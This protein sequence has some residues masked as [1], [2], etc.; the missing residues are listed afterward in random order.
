L[1]PSPAI[2]RRIGPYEVRSP[3]GKGGMGQVWRA[4]DTRLNR[5]VAIKISTERFTLRFDRESRIVAALNHPNICTVFDVGPNYMVMELVEGVTLAERIRTGRIPVD[6]ALA[7]AEQI[8]SGLEAAHEK[9]VVHRDLKPANIMIRPDGVV[10]IL[11]FGLARPGGPKPEVTPDSPTL[12]ETQVGVIL[13]TAAY[14]SPEQAE[15]KPVDARADIFSYGVVLYE[16][17]SGRKAFP[18]SSPVSVLGAILHKEV[19]PLEAPPEIA[20]VVNRCLRKSPQDRFQT[21][22]EVRRASREPAARPVESV[23]SIAVLP[24]SNAGG[25][26]EN[27]YF[28]D[29]LSEEILN[30]LARLPGLKVTARTSAFAFRG[31]DEDVSAIAR[32]LRVSNILE[33]G[34]R[35]SGNRIRVT[36]RLIGAADGYQIWSERY[37]RELT[38]IFAIQDEIASA[39]SNALHVTLVTSRSESQRYRPNLPAYEAWMKGWYQ[40]HTGL[41]SNLD[42]ARAHFEEAIALD[43]NY[44]APHTEMGAYYYLLAFYGMM[45]AREALPLVRAEARRALEMPSPDLRAHGLLGIVAAALDY[46]WNT[47]ENHF[48]IASAITPA[49]FEMRWS[50]GAFYHVPLGHFEEAVKAMEGML[51]RD[52]LFVSSRLAIAAYLNQAGRPDRALDEARSALEINPNNWYAQFIRAESLVLKGMYSEAVEAAGDAFQGAPSDPR[53]L[54]LLAGTLFR[55]GDERR[56]AELMPWIQNSPIGMLV[57][58]LVRGEAEAAAEWF[59]RAI[60]ERELMLL[61]YANGAFTESLRLTEHWPGLAKRLNLGE[62]KITG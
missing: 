29:G 1:I 25:N 44:A 59:G 61:L 51:E 52:P 45:R 60:D 23:P 56:A 47:A 55:S 17:F 40:F 24:F 28:S 4:L 50:C 26:P 31:T 12:L 13:G 43:P 54:G 49:T 3:L 57:Y 10:K 53:V 36:V 41:A 11:D 30:T 5:E 35:R 62:G 38:D 20:A 32:K 14:M 9:G 34:V 58:E 18:G 33:G 46:D 21:M 42:R 2:G 39:I 48:S 8:A 19:E 7:I 16:M 27:Q 6:E 22:A 15:G 37:D